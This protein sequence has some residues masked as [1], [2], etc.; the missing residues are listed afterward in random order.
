MAR[1]SWD[2]AG[3]D[4]GPRASAGYTWWN[5]NAYGP[6]D[7][8]SLAGGEE[9][10]NA[11]ALPRSITRAPIMPHGPVFARDLLGIFVFSQRNERRMSEEQDTR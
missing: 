8:T 2:D 9:P 1:S 10:M 3:G 7:A 4:H 11:P 6:A 5:R